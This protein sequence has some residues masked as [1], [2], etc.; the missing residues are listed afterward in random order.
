MV[1]SLQR[2]GGSGSSGGGGGGGSWAQLVLGEGM[3][4]AEVGVVTGEGGGRWDGG[5][6]GFQGGAWEA[7]RWWDSGE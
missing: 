1:T 7:D 5:S 6:D 4:V 3:N 2:S